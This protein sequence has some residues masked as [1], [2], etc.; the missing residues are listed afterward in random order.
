MRSPSEFVA[1]AAR[2]TVRSGGALLTTLK[3]AAR[4]LTNSLPSRQKDKKKQKPT[5]LNVCVVG[6]GTLDKGHQRAIKCIGKLVQSPQEANVLVVS[7]Y[8]SLCSDPRVLTS[9]LVGLVGATRLVTFE[10]IGALATKLRDVPSLE[11]PRVAARIDDPRLCPG[12]PTAGSKLDRRLVVIVDADKPRLLSQL[13]S[14]DLRTI[15]VAHGAFAF[16]VSDVGV[17]RNQE[18]LR[19]FKYLVSGP[20]ER[21]LVVGGPRVTEPLASGLQRLVDHLR[22]PG[23]PTDDMAD[24]TES[25]GALE[26][27]TITVLGFAQTCLGKGP[28]DLKPAPLLRNLMTDVDEGPATAR[29][30]ARV[31]QRVNIREWRIIG[32]RHVREISEGTVEA[33]IDPAVSGFVVQKG[34]GVSGKCRLVETQLVAVDF[35]TGVLA[36]ERLYFCADDPVLG[37]VGSVQIPQFDRIE[38]AS[39]G[40]AV[41][42]PWDES[43][44]SSN[45]YGVFAAVAR[46]NA[47]RTVSN[48][49][50]PLPAVGGSSII[51]RAW[52]TVASSLET[53]ARR[54]SGGG[55]SPAPVAPLDQDVISD[56]CRVVIHSSARAPDQTSR[57]DV[58]AEVSSVLDARH[59]AQERRRDRRACNTISGAVLQ[60]MGQS[61]AKSAGHVFI[62]RIDDKKRARR[63]TSRKKA[64][65]GETGSYGDDPFQRTYLPALLNEKIKS[66][67]TREAAEAWAKTTS[68]RAAKNEA[69][70]PPDRKPWTDG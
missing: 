20:L 65:A 31:G 19:E 60:Q 30:D 56:P 68:W 67:N 50:A 54:L 44:A 11:D 41:A 61:L 53:A 33:I 13:S 47:P 45:V 6:V 57:I 38:W 64:E 22:P 36:W 24:V 14:H 34:I 7:P 52:K 12:P 43:G 69:D 23:S 55:S 9:L 27:S 42:A 2:Q 18:F 1:D 8:V 48:D 21:V 35:T 17:L 32:G 51:S 26:V 66:K 39:D 58:N 10:L 4:A 5:V 59:E 37:L 70:V 16:I 46:D 28:E 63:Y 29:R 49:W 40:N 25:T 62:W 3:R 15:A